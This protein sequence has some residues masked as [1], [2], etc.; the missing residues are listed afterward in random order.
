MLEA[1]NSLT[2]DEQAGFESVFQDLSKLLN[3]CFE[4]WEANRGS[5]ADAG[6]A[7]TMEELMEDGSVQWSWEALRDATWTLGSSES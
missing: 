5:F 7:D 3:S 4:D 2:D 6:A 1:W